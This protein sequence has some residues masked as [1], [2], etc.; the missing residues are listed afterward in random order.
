MVFPIAPAFN[1]LFLSNPLNPFSAFLGVP[2]P[3]LGSFAL[4]PAAFNLIGLVPTVQ[5]LSPGMLPAQIG[6]GGATFV[7][8]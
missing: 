4:G 2:V 6:L 1:P 3:G 7:R 5:F 8:A